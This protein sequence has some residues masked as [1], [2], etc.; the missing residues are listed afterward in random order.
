MGNRERERAIV[1]IFHFSFSLC[2]NAIIV[3]RVNLQF[4]TEDLCYKIENNIAR[5]SVF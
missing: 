3:N 1:E 4:Y 2:F 5:A